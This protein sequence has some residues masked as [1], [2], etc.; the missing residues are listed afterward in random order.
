V[1]AH[2]QAIGPT[3]AALRLPGGI[4][5]DSGRHSRR[6]GGSVPRNGVCALA[7]ARFKVAE[8][9]TWIAVATPD[10]MLMISLKAHWGMRKTTTDF[11]RFGFARGRLTPKQR[12][13]LLTIDFEAFRPHAVAPWTTA[14]RH[15]AEASRL[16]GWKFCVFIALEDVVRL[17]VEDEDGYR[18]FLDAIRDLHQAGARFYPHNHCVF[19]PATGRRPQDQESSRAPVTTYRKRPSLFYDVVYRNKLEFRSWCKTLGESYEG[20]LADA[21]IP[22]PGQLAFR[23]GG[24][25]HGVTREDIADYL[26]G[27]ADMGVTFESSASSGVFDTRTWRIG[28]PFGQ[29][30]FRLDR[31]LIEV[32][33]CDFADC[34]APVVSSQFASWIARLFFRAPIWMPPL[35]RRGALVTVIHFDHLFHE[36]R[37]DARR[38]FSLAD[39]GEVAQR[40]DRFM[41]WLS[42]VRRLSG[43]TSVTFDELAFDERPDSRKR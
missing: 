18:I 25:D 4:S 28:A 12:D 20:F 32:A 24:W 8:R 41:S 29:N 16:G 19:D 5:P 3:P 43:F 21:R 13:W 30:T 6:T 7:K 38:L 26:D 1:A 27:L 39:D 42:Y 15:W 34:G 14:M 11:E 10:P 22:R 35:R 31:S 40:I 33:P 2:R 23:A 9:L 17:R 36:G 37:G